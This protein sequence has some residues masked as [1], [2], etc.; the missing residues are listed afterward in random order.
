MLV[1]GE[2][3]VVVLDFGLVSELSEPDKRV[4]RDHQV[5]GTPVYMAPEQ[6]L[7]QRVGPAADYYAHGSA[8][9]VGRREEL[10]TL[11][12]ALR[13]VSERG[14]AA[15][16]H[17][18]GRSGYGKSAVVRRFRAGLR[19]ADAIVLH[20]RCREREI[21]PYKGVDA[22][23]DVL[24]SYLRRL[25]ASERTKLRPVDL[26]ALTRVFP[27]FDDIWE[28]PCPQ[29][30]GPREVLQLGEVTLRKLLCAMSER[31]PLVVHIDDF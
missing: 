3:R 24:S 4:T 23:V 26:A 19:G 30:L 22:I 6:A 17:L 1:T 31:L 15:V 8:A 5:L 2:G 21:L 10:R 29:N 25:P 11:E 9:F 16:V 13:A 14:G 20:G 12:A 18:R 7:G 28:P 27:V